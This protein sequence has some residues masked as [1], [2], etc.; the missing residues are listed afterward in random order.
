MVKSAFPFS[1]N[2]GG[3][4]LSVLLFSMLLS[5]CSQLETVEN[6]NDQGVLM[7]KYTRRK[8]NFAKEGKY[9][10]FHPNGKLFEESWYV[11]DTL[12]GERK[13]YYESGALQSVEHLDRGSYDGV[14][15]KF[16]ENGQISNEGQYVDNEMSGIWK[17]YFE[18][19]ELMEEV[20]FAQNNENGPFV[21]FHKNGKP[22]VKGTYENG[23]NEQGELLKYDENGELLEKMY[24]QYGACATTWSRE[25]GDLQ[26]DTARI[27][28]LGE[29]RRR[30]DDFE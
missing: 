29:M 23:D 18:T 6:K 15:R 24:C 7:E 17:R 27:R 30:S 12:D 3:G 16:Y 21:I 13:L 1:L 5:A 8:D 10:S 14:Y 2:S 9:Q 22:S 11:N 25:K 26:I 28:E 19:G 4:W 20:T